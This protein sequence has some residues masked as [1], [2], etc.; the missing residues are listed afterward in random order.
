MSEEI[1]DKKKL[2]VLTGIIAIAV[3]VVGSIIFLNGVPGIYTSGTDHE[4]IVLSN[5]EKKESAPNY[6]AEGNMVLSLESMGMR[7]EIPGEFTTYETFEGEKMRTDMT[8]SAPQGMDQDIQN[9]EDIETLETSTFILPEGTFSCIEETDEW[10]CQEGEEATMG[11]EMSPAKEEMEKLIENEALEFKGDVEER[12]VAGRTCDYVE[13]EIDA[14][15]ME[16]AQMQGTE[17]ATIEISQCYDKET[18]ISLIENIKFGTPGESLS[19]EMEVNSLE[20][21]ADMPGD[22]FDLPAE[23]EPMQQMPMY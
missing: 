14:D 3:L 20:L 13:M 4:E 16:D 19:I 9:Q 18:G 11:T 21:E 8:M 6:I 10:I 12:E 22:I 15:K 5:I 7:E 17:G 23:P 1:K 2:L